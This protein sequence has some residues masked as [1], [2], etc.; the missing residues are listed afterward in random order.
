MF[1]FYNF[2]KHLLLNIITKLLNIFIRRDKNVILCGSWMGD[3]FSDNSRFLFQYLDN[4]KEKYSISDVVWVTRN[5]DIYNELVNMKYNVC[6][7]HS[8][9]SY[10]YHL[11]A[12]IHVVCNVPYQ[13]KMYKGDILGELSLGAKKIQLW[14]GIPL[15]GLGNKSNIQEKKYYYIRKKLKKSYVYNH[16]IRTAGGWD[17]YKLLSTSS[18]LNPIYRDIFGINIENI[19]VSIYPRNT[20]LLDFREQEKKVFE[21]I[22]NFSMVILYAPT[23]RE[24]SNKPITH[25]LEN[26]KLLE[27]LKDNN[28]AWIEKRHSA[29]NI[30]FGVYEEELKNIINLD[31][32]FDLNVLTTRMDILITDYS[33]ISFDALYFQKSVLYYIPDIDDYYT[34]DR[35]FT[36]DFYEFTC[37]EYCYNTNDIFNILSNFS[38]ND[39]KNMDKSI[40]YNSIINKV[41]SMSKDMNNLVKQIIS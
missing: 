24:H 12:G 9:K 6:L 37:G 19:I 31:S 23:F 40:K 3:T 32:T 14:H 10:Y 18:F 2:F 36:L 13:T 4:H 1:Y 27:L 35:G 7:M 38:K 17:N 28:I 8:L 29:D 11:K 34:K 25:P 30:D 5:K 39:F 15:K 21:K 16:L 33:S 26:K 22:A 20:V 41:Y